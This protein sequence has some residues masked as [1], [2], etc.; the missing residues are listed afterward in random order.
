[1]TRQSSTLIRCSISGED[2]DEDPQQ[3][4]LKSVKQVY[5]MIT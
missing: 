1:M 4:K 3:F 5:D 2:E